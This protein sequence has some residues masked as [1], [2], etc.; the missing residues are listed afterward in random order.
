MI[1]I[2]DYLPEGVILAEED[3]EGQISVA[4][5]IE[6]VR[7]QNVSVPVE[8]IRFIGLPAGYH[9]SI[10]EPEESYE[11][12]LIGLNSELAQIDINAL[13]PYVDVTAWT[14]GE[15]NT[16]IESGYYRMPLMVSLPEDSTVSLDENWINVHI[17]EPE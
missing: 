11:I 13:E 8:S 17:T 9:A 3:F 16:E 10:T 14:A 15:E 5:R 7:R 2:H 12:A 4:V 1:N 6:Q